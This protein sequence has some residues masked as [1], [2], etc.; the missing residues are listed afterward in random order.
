[1]NQQKHRLSV[2]VHPRRAEVY[3][4]RT[5]LREG[6]VHHPV[7]QPADVLAAWQLL[8]EIKHSAKATAKN[9]QEGIVYVGRSY[10]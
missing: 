5:A 7:P 4:P 3:L 9:L 2:L 8:V 10:S 6:S 1:M